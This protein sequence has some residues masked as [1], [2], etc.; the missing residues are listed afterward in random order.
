MR[1]EVLDAAQ[2]ADVARAQVATDPLDPRRLQPAHHQIGGQVRGPH[3]HALQQDPQRNVLSELGVWPGIVVVL[4]INR[5][6]AAVRNAREPVL[7]PDGLFEV[8]AQAIGGQQ[9]SELHGA[10]GVEALPGAKLD[11]LAGLQVMKGD[12]NRLRVRGEDQRERLLKA[13]HRGS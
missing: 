12:S 8:H 6:R 5:E 10:R 7:H 11:P 2:D 4:R 1:L 3:D 9:D 13:A